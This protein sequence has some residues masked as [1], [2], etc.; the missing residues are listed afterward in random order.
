MVEISCLRAS[1]SEQF[2]Y[3]EMF[4]VPDCW[5]GAGDLCVFVCGSQGCAAV[6]LFTPQLAQVVTHLFMQFSKER[7]MKLRGGKR[8]TIE[9]MNHRKGWVLKLML[10]SALRY[11]CMYKMGVLLYILL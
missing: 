1:H 8:K 7:E 9:N 10:I 5:L 2:E 3:Q 6:G 4:G 11:V